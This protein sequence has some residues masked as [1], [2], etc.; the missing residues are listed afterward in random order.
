MLNNRVYPL[1]KWSARST[2]GLRRSAPLVAGRHKTAVPHLSGVSCALILW[3]SF[4]SLNPTET[5]TLSAQRAGLI[6]VVVAMRQRCSG[7]RR[8]ALLAE[9]LAEQEREVLSTEARRAA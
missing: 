3:A 8:A 6:V 9:P 4:I 2:F 5:L 7:T 1:V